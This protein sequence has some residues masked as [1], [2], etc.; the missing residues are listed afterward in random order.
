MGQREGACRVLAV[1][2]EGQRALGKPGNR[3][4]DNI[5]MDPK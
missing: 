4:D 5:K 1:K 2:C 3:W